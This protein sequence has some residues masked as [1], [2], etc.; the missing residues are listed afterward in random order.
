MKSH[1]LLGILNI[2]VNIDRITIQDLAERFEVSKRTIFRDLDTLNK[3]GI[4]I[5]TYSGVGGGVSLVEGYKHNK[6]V[7]SKNDIKNIFIALSGLMS[8]NKNNDLINLMA[9]II[10]EESKTILG[11]SDYLI[12]LSSW[13]KDSI[14]QEKVSNLHK[15][16]QSNRYVYIEYISKNSRRERTIQ[17]YKLIFKQS[18]WYLYGLCEDNDEFRL[19]KINRIASYVILDKTFTCKLINNINFISNFGVNYLNEKESESFYNV[20]LEYEAINEFALTQKIDAKL[21]R[22]SNGELKGYITLEVNNLDWATDFVMSLL[23]KVKVVSP[24][25][26][27]EKIKLKIKNI[28]EFY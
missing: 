22:R 16:I 6:T 7:F 2:L 28:S 17:P 14:T 9:K 24:P 10:P 25:E 19:F 21:L 1:R 12:D 13:F 26:L 3:S 11:E 4:P 18:Y 23:D 15:A 5:V 27:K 8:I 20:I